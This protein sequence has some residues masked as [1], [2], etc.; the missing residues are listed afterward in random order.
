MID[1]FEPPWAAES[2]QLLD[3]RRGERI[4]QLTAHTPHASRALLDAAGDDGMVVVVEPNPALID[5]VVAL[6]HP[7]IHPI[8]LDPTGNET[9]GRFD[10]V[11]AGPIWN[12]GWPIERWGTIVANALRPGGRFVL[13]LPAES[14]CETIA[15]AWR[16]AGEAAGLGRWRGPTEEVAASGLRDLGLRNVQGVVGT[17]LARFD[18]PRALASLATAELA[19][20]DD[21]FESLSLRITEQMRTNDEIEVVFRRTCVHGMR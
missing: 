7:A 3:A 20:D 14:G 4:L 19:V 17:H 12:V 18:S 15:I 11:Y 6:E 5:R 13:D 1:S 8:T 9:F 16:A 2:L 21:F 10:A